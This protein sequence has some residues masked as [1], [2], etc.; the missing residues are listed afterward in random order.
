LNQL[1]IELEVRNPDEKARVLQGILVDVREAYGHCPR[2]FTFAG[3]WD[4]DQIESNRGTPKN[5][6]NS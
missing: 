1:E 2:A 3:L 6:N 5:L 4:L